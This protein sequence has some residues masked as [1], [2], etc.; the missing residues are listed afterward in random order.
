METKHFM[1]LQCKCSIA[2]FAY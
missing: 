1:K 2:L